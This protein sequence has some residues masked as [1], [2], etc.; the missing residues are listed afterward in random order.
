MDATTFYTLLGALGVGGLVCFGI[1][2]AGWMV[3]TLQ[4]C[5]YR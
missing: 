2:W 3:R 4:R 1:G 5:G